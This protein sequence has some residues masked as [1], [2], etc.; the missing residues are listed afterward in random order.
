MVYFEKWANT[1][2]ILEISWY[3]WKIEKIGKFMVGKLTKV[4]EILE[5]SLFYQKIDNFFGEFMFF[6]DN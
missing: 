2:K 1:F 4:F 6:L 5:N 3:F